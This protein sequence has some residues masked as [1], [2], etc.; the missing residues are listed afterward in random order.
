M[1][2]FQYLFSVKLCYYFIRQ[3][4][5]VLHTPIAGLVDPEDP[6]QLPCPLDEVKQYTKILIK[7]YNVSW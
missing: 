3:A 2:L 5:A 4:F 6:V 1:S 7:M